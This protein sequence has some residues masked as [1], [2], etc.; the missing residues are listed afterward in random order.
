MAV[1]VAVAFAIHTPFSLGMERKLQTNIEVAVRTTVGQELAGLI[2]P[3]ETLATESAGYYEYYSNATML[4]YPG[5][6]SVRARQAMQQLPPEHRSI[7]DF[8]DAVQADWLALRPAEWAGLQRDY[9]T[10]AARYDP[11]DTVQSPP[12]S[13]VFDAEGRPRIELAGYAKDASSWQI[14]ILHKVR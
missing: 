8:L 10:T 1:A 3:G 9:P 6:T 5:L 4:D 14:V 11:L 2:K 13:I 12:G 7:I